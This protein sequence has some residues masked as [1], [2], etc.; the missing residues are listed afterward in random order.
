MN[1][2]IAALA[3]FT[4]YVLVM[5]AYLYRKG[6]RIELKPRS[7]RR[8]SDGNDKPSDYLIEDE[9]EL[10]SLH[11]KYLG[12][13]EADDPQNQS[14]VKR[15]YVSEDQ[16]ILAYIMIADTPQ[17][18]P[19]CT[20]TLQSFSNDFEIFTTRAEK[21][22]QPESPRNRRSY[23][24]PNSTIAELLEHHVDRIN[25]FKSTGHRFENITGSNFCKLTHE[26]EKEQIKFQE[27]KGTIKKLPDGIYVF[28]Y[29][30]HLYAVLRNTLSAF[31]S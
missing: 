11:F 15:A 27:K 6:F 4:L 30:Y 22:H 5:A 31:R 2:L 17:I 18:G 7:F 1:L 28:T 19:F 29:R 14:I 24:L 13:E 21:P 3:L 16:S 26:Y 10:S 8:P 23:L 20:I 25:E 12:E 9:K